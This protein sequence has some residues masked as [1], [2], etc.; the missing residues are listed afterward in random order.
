[1]SR[2]DKHIFVCVH[3]RA[4]G[5]SRGCCHDRGGADVRAA[6]VQGLAQRGLKD[7]VRANKAGCL[8]ACELGPAVVIYPQG[9]WYL[10][11]RPEDADQ[12]IESSI[13]GD[14]VIGRLVAAE[15]DWNYLRE[16]RIDI[17]GEKNSAKIRGQS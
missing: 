5:H 7:K 1:M 10:S 16:C 17:E 14:E 6:L 11:V 4:A 2:F 9:V 8:D 3:E 15:G 13:I 12:I